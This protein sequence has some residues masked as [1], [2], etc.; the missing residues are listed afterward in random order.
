MG[1]RRRRRRSGASPLP[2]RPQDLR[3]VGPVTE[4]FSC[5]YIAAETFLRYLR[6]NLPGDGVG[7]SGRADFI[8]LERFRIL[9]EAGVGTS[10]LGHLVFKRVRLIRHQFCVRVHAGLYLG[11]SWQAGND[12]DAN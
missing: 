4:L 3:L 9:I 6:L 10:G 1:W 11:I 2:A 12:R 7:P 8:S 5:P